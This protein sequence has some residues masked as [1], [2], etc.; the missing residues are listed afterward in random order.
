[1][2]GAPQ[3]CFRCF[4]D[5]LWILYGYPRPPLIERDLNKKR[6]FQFFLAEIFCGR[7]CQR[8]TRRLVGREG[9][10]TV[11]AK[12]ANDI[13]NIIWQNSADGRSGIRARSLWKQL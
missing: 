5:V 4:M 7:H 1:M 8:T 6:D 2:L 10:A 13:Q 9:G 3:L 12:L 11:N